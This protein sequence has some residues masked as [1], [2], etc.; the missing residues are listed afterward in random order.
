[1]NKIKN[2]LLLFSNKEIEE[3]K[4]K[5]HNQQLQVAVLIVS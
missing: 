3:P 4:L 2:F 1:M 5:M